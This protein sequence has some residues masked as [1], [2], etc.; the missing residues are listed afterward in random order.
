MTRGVFTGETDRALRIHDALPWQFSS[1]RSRVER[2][3]N[4]TRLPGQP[5]DPRHL[6][7]CRYSAAW[8]PGH[9]IV[10]ALMQ[11]L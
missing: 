4:K 2:V 3:T 6:T 7:V 9:H 1:S 11:T 5:R 8:Y 10:N